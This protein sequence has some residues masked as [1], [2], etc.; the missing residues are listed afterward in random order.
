MKLFSNTYK[1]RAYEKYGGLFNDFDISGKSG[2]SVC[3]TFIGEFNAGKSTIVNSILGKSLLP[4]D[5]FQTTATI[6]RV[7]FG[8]SEGFEVIGHNDEIMM[9]G[10]SID[11]LM[12]FNADSGEEFE[13]IKWIEISWPRLPEGIE[14][15][16]TPGFNDPNP[17]RDKTFLSI[18]PLADLIIFVCDAN[19]ALKGT[20]IPYIEKFFLNTL[21]QSYFVFN[22]ADG[23][24]SRMRLELVENDVN[25]KL[26]EFFSRTAEFF[27][28]RDCRDL[29]QT[30]KNV[31]VN[32]HS[33]F[34]S[35]I[36]AL[37]GASDDMEPKL[38]E[39]L[40]A[41]Y[42]KLTRCIFSTIQNKGSLN[43]EW[44]TR[45]FLSRCNVELSQIDSI[46]KLFE[47]YSGRGKEIKTSLSNRL[48]AQLR[49]TKN[50]QVSMKNSRI[51]LEAFLNK[52]IDTALKDIGGMLK[53][54]IGNWGGSMLMEH[55]QR[56]MQG[57]LNRMYEGSKKVLGNDLKKSIDFSQVEEFDRASIDFSGI[58]NITYMQ[59]SATRASVAA[60]SGIAGAAAF[61]IGTL[62]GGPAVGSIASAVVTGIAGVGLV[63]KEKR[64]IEKVCRGIVDQTKE[65]LIRVK[66][67][68]MNSAENK[69]R[70]LEHHILKGTKNVQWQI[71]ELIDISE[72]MDNRGLDKLAGKRKKIEL[73]MAEAQRQILAIREGYL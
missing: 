14:L 34:V 3:I 41:D 59:R 40:N 4:T 49:S 46:K 1:T 32:D 52:A 24:K 60:K 26:K 22:H 31:D 8:S 62:F 58:S 64:E 10:D 42:E 7:K 72:K 48:N 25:K 35:G 33:F 56:E 30:I 29:A 55:Y 27:E 68:I 16:D 39:K 43:E 65:T 21:A 73:A 38:C 18:L 12:S 53:I 5:V 50:L 71:M 23:L 28:K 69:L 66:Y 45:Q 54:N 15:I 70:A 51:N 61:G 47:E 13:R 19:Q 11:Q 67:E 17:Q 36:L 2:D 9:E 63:Q 6:N 37:E 57:I 20:E 44:K